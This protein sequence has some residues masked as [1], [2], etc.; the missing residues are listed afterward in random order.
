MPQ[1]SIQWDSIHVTHVCPGSSNEQ[2]YS[3]NG[4]L[5]ARCSQ[6]GVHSGKGIMDTSPLA[7]AKS[8]LSLEFWRLPAVKFNVAIENGH[9]HSELSHSRLWFSIAML[10]YQR[11]DPMDPMDPEA[12]ICWLNPLSRGSFPV[13]RLCEVSFGQRRQ[14]LLDAVFFG[15]GV[16]FTVKI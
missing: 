10:V 14:G 5:V 12:Q 4:L 8:W 6:T 3:L 1:I 13:G 11:V 16:T 2:S 15:M 7:L 9:R